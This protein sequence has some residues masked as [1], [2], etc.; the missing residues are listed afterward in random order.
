MKYL[1]ITQ[2]VP[3][4][5]P[6]TVA[7]WLFSQIGEMLQRTE[8][9]SQLTEEGAKLGA[10]D[11]PV[12]TRDQRRLAKKLRSFYAHDVQRIDHHGAVHFYNKGRKKGPKN[13]KKTLHQ[14]TEDWATIYHLVHETLVCYS[15]TTLECKTCGNTSNGTNLPDC[16]HCIAPPRSN[17][18][19]PVV[20]KPEGANLQINVEFGR[21]DTIDEFINERRKMTL[22]DGAW[23]VMMETGQLPTEFDRIKIGDNVI[24]EE[25][26][27][28]TLR[29]SW[30]IPRK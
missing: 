11:K 14:I 7:R 25:Q 6:E 9:I 1:R 24:P 16:G 15:E 20:I 8:W 10:F 29:E 3:N 12:W 28:R 23:Q 19:E 5:A 17:S 30:P 26:K 4:D 27:P 2:P 18:R 21:A 22:A 13:T